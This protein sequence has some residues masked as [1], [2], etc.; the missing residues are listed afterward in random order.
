MSDIYLLNE[1]A[2][3]ILNTIPIAVSQRTTKLYG[4]Q[5]SESLSIN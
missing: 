1:L 5:V 4:E 2:D 3:I